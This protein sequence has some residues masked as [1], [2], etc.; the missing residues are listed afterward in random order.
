MSKKGYFEPN[1]HYLQI[2]LEAGF[3]ASGDFDL[4]KGDNDEEFA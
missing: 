1:L 3:A 4:V 2:R